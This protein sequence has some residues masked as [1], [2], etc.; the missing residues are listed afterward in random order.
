MPREIDENLLQRRLGDRVLRNREPLPLLLHTPEDRADRRARLRQPELD[1]RAAAGALRDVGAL[2]EGGLRELHEAVEGGLQVC[3]GPERDIKLVAG[4]VHCLE[5]RRR[6]QAD[7]LAVHHDADA[8]AKRLALVHAVRRE[9]RRPALH[10]RGNEA[11]EEPP[12]LGVHAR[13]RLVEEHDARVSDQ[14]DAEGELPLRAA[15]EGS[16]LT[17]CVGRERQPV[18]HGLDV[19]RYPGGGDALDPGEEGQVLPRRQRRGE[20]VELRAVAEELPHLSLLRRDVEASERG[21]PAGAEL[22]AREDLHG[23]RLAGAV[24]AEVAEALALGDRKV[25]AL[26]RHLRRCAGPAGEDLPQPPHDDHLNVRSATQH[27]LRLRADV[28]VHGAV[29]RG[30]RHGWPALEHGAEAGRVERELQR[31]G[32]QEPDDGADA[33][34]DEVPAEDVEVPR[35]AA[36]HRAVVR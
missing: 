22:L 36:R 14:G 13:R 20:C 26:Q 35:V 11:P 24:H 34:V 2:C 10:R 31:Q 32:H 16:G 15:G 1:V 29:V 9:D 4:A 30:L 27:A 21:A 25:H 6:A 17:V 18:Q 8:P 33:H 5:V 23:R 12:G 19:A 7:E 28:V 3:P